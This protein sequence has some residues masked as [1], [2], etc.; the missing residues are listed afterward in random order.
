MR[1]ANSEHAKFVSQAALALFTYS[2]RA[3]RRKASRRLFVMYHLIK[4]RF[5]NP[6]GKRRCKDLAKLL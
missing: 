3:L 5:L 2:G 1:D 6:S 4:W